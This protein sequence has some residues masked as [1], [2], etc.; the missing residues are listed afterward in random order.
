MNAIFAIARIAL[1]LATAQ[2]SHTVKF[3]A[4]RP[5]ES[6]QAADAAGVDL[7]ECDD[8]EMTEEK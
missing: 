3:D 4:A 6:C 8:V 1:T 7:V 5:V 2:P